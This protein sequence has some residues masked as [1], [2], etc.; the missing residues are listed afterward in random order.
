MNEEL[1]PVDSYEKSKK[2]KKKKENLKILMK[3]LQLLMTLEK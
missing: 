1:D 3:R 2:V